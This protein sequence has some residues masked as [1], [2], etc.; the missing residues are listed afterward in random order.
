M[1]PMEG[2]EAQA[3]IIMLYAALQNTLGWHGK[4]SVDIYTQSTL[5]KHVQALF[6]QIMTNLYKSDTTE[7]FFDHLTV[8]DGMSQNT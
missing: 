1:P 8:R 3:Y 4:D 5:T 2:D 7:F 6:E